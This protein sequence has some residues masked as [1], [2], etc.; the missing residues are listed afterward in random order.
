MPSA[1]CATIISFSRHRCLLFLLLS[2]SP[3][4]LSCFRFAV[5]SF[6]VHKRCHEYVTF[7]CPGADKG[8]DSDVSIHFVHHLSGNPF[9]VLSL[10]YFFFFYLTYSEHLY[11]YSVHSDTKKHKHT[12]NTHVH[13]PS[14]LYFSQCIR[15]DLLDG[16]RSQIIVWERNVPLYWHIGWQVDI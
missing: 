1:L 5:C 7:K 10:W 6:V 9:L 11:K 14:P 13:T 4:W 8:A 3:F 2:F 12:K 16:F 15:N